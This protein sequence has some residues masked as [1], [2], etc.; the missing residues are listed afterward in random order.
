M[1]VVGGG[2]GVVVAC[3]SRLSLGTGGLLL[4]CGV[5]GEVGASLVPDL[6]CEVVGES[7]NVPCWWRSAWRHRRGMFGASRWC[8]A[9]WIC[10]LLGRACDFG[11]G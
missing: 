2:E 8:C 6:A 1:V 5:G 4:A 9:Q 10:L 11:A 7:V 3:S